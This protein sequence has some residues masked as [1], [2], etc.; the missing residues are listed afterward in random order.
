MKT[1][2]P[3]LAVL[4][5]VALV[6]SISVQSFAASA[7][8]TC[9]VVSAGPVTYSPNNLVYY[10]MAIRLTYVSG[11]TTAPAT[12]TKTFYAPAGHEK[13]FLAVALTAIANGKNVCAMVNFDGANT[14]VHN[15]CMCL[16]TCPD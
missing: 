14:T 12:T 3:A 9:T 16:D 7:N 5:L 15:L 11:G 6:I 2:K 10:K 8:Y 4:V 1:R 13:E